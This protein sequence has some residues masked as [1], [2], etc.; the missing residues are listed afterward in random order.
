MTLMVPPTVHSSVRSGAERR[1]FRVIESAPETDDW[2]CL[3]SLGLARHGTKRRAEIDFCLLTPY[4]IVVLEVKG[5]RV[6]RECGVWI[7]TDRFGQEHRKHEGPFEQAARAMFALERDVRSQFAEGPVR[8]ALYAYGVLFPDIEFD[9]TGSE[10]DPALVYDRRDR[11]HPFL[12]YVR[13]VL[14]F[15]RSKKKSSAMRMDDVQLTELVAFLRA[16]FDL[17]PSANALLD[18]TGRELAALTIEQ[19][20]VLDSAATEERLIVEGPA[21]SGKT[22][23]AMEAARR[24][25]RLGRRVLLLCY[26]RM[27]S[28]RLAS[29]LNDETFGGSVTARTV[30]S[31]FRATIEKSTLTEEFSHLATETSDDSLYSELYPEY[32]WLAAMEASTA[33]YDIIIIDEAQ[34]ILSEPNLAALGEMLRGGLTN[35][36]W[37]AFLD[38]NDQACVYGRMDELAL[39]KLRNA[40]DRWSVL[41]FNC[42]NTRPIGIQINVVAAPTGRTACRTDGPPVEFSTYGAPGGLYGK[43]ERVV[44]DL[45]SR[46]VPR[47]RVSILLPNLPSEKD[48]RRLERMGVTRL[49]ESD[50]ELLGSEKLDRFTWS[51]VSGFKGLENDIVVLAGVEDIED[52]WWRAVT[53]VGMSRARVQLFVVAHERC[54]SIREL[55]FA[56]ELEHQLKKNQLL[57]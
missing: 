57:P 20:S 8:K 42:R 23:L 15:A 21:G 6:R 43:L 56:E 48:L 9:A 5:G 28:R 14:E 50:V 55:R 46:K 33:L 38:A 51:P 45:R 32:A 44:N 24:E 25:A 47:G 12:A 2:I 36:R 19:M 41:T 27:L 10:A 29:Q 1:L 22:L 3:H 54:T 39:K 30:Y 7:F 35:G 40:A 53:Y 52:E 18:D 4:G 17:V 13:R 49:E 16:D 26:N 31:H 37:R 34:D 11:R